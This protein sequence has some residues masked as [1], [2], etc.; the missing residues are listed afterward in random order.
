MR[1]RESLGRVE[2]L[3][4][5]THRGPV[6]RGALADR[7]L[8]IYTE[9][10]AGVA[11]KLD[12]VAAAHL[13]VAR[14]VDP[15][16]DREQQARASVR[17]GTAGAAAASAA[18]AAARAFRSPEVHRLEGLAAGG[19]EARDEHPRLRRF[20]GRASLGAVPLGEPGQKLELP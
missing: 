20:A 8:V 15:V 5:R 17:R 16:R 2:D 6:F 11:G 1:R 4:A 9:G 12:E 14:G 10:T 3:P 18:A 7:S 13:H 19:G